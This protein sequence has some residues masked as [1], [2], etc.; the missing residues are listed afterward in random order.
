MI[1]RMYTISVEPARPLQFS[2]DE[3]RSFLNKKLAEYAALPADY[4][5][6]FLHRYTVLQCKQLKT[7]LIV[8]GISQGAGCLCQLTADGTMLG[9]GESICRITSRDPVIRSELFGVTDHVISYEFLTPWIA[10]NQQ[11]AKKF[12]DLDGKPE[13]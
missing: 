4:V 8:T 12:Y 9:D 6:R 10:L 3:L 7:E 13:R 2:L 1:L 5:D 11:N